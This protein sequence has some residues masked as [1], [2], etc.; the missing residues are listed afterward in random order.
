MKC[1]VLVAMD[2]FKGS[3]SSLEAGLAVKRGFDR[4]SFETRV[5]P[6]ADGGEGTLEMLSHFFELSLLSEDVQDLYKKTIGSKIYYNEKI[7]FLEAANAA[8]L[9]EKK[10]VFKASSLGFGQEILLAA[11]LKPQEIILGIG[12]TGVNDGGMGLLQALG[13]SFYKDDRPLEA[14]LENL[15]LVNRVEGQLEKLPPIRVAS[16]VN[17]PLLGELGASAVYGPQK[18]LSRKDIAR[19]DQAMDNFSSLLEEHFGKRVRELPGAGAAGGLGFALL[20]LGAKL[21]P[22]FSLLMELCQLEAHLDWADLVITGEGSFDAQS[23]QGKGPGELAVLAKSKGK[24]TLG[25]F[26]SVSSSSQS[27]DGIFSIQPGPISLERAM[28]KDLALEHLETTARA[29]SSTISM[30]RK[31]V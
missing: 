31:L 14:S 30:A 21:E 22:G 18:G 15:L 1:K 26:G 8:G 13:L 27:F 2:S 6:L 16:D 9:R 24:G 11:S 28:D 29:L 17:N 4:E 3:L 19:V 12:G 25:L 10:E 7:A 5:L 20:L 23:L